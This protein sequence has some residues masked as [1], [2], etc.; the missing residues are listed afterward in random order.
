MPD[1]TPRRSGKRQ[2][3][4]TAAYQCFRDHGYHDTSVDMICRQAGVSKGSMYWHY[5]SKLD[6][7]VD[8]LSQWSDEMMDEIAEQFEGI[9][10]G[11]DYLVAIAT[12]L[13]REIH[14][15]RAVVPLWLEYTEIARREPEV[16]RALARFFSRGR[17]AITEMIRPVVGEQ[18]DDH[19]L[20]GIAATIFGAYIGLM[21]QDSCDPD[22]ADARSAVTDLMSVLQPWLS[23]SR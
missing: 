13:E 19:Q 5:T 22:G 7:F 20:R 14:R 21:V 10:R 1:D 16:Q 4:R 23:A 9:S 17:S 6:I 11:N 3:I 12:A 15:G 18:V 2:L 8:I